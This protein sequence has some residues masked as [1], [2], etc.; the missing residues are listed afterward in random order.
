MYDDELV[1][2]PLLD[3]EGCTGEEV[4]NFFKIPDGEIG[5]PSAVLILTVTGRVNGSCFRGI[6]SGG[7]IGLSSRFLFFFFSV[8]ERSSDFLDVLLLLPLIDRLSLLLLDVEFIGV[9]VIDDLILCAGV[10]DIGI[11][12]IPGRFSRPVNTEL[13]LDDEEDTEEVDG[14][15]VIGVMLTDGDKL[16]LLSSSLSSLRRAFFLLGSLWLLLSLRE[17]SLSQSEYDFDDLFA[18]FPSGAGKL[19]DKFVPFRLLSMVEFTDVATPSDDTFIDVRDDEVI[20]TP[21]ELESLLL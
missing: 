7:P 15:D 12:S 5:E 6:F 11:I 19:A 20:G 8:L 9:I 16:L 18:F 21:K 1:L 13:M 17:L 2:L 3:D 14:N 4:V 10:D